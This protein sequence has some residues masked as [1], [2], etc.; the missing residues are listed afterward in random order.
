MDERITRRGSLVKLGGFMAAVLGAGAWKTA[1]A[2]GGPSGVASGAV[3]CV[4]APEQTEGP[5][6][7]SGEQLRR[8]NTCRTPAAPLALRLRFS[9]A[10]TDKVFKRSPYSSRPNR[11]QRNATDMVC[12]NGGKRSLLSMKRSGA[13]YVG[14]ITM[15]VVRS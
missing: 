10:L 13:G 15:G 4:L 3:T 11:D 8:N 1:S 2:E 9:D 12:R 5:Y 7:I 6:Y 14:R